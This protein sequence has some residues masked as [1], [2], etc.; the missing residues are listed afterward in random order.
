M[1]KNW[2]CWNGANA[3]TGEWLLFLDADVRTHPAAVRTT[4]DWA[5][6]EGADLATIAPRLEMKGF[7]ERVV[8]P[9]YIQIVLTYFRASHVNRDRSKQRWRTAG[10]GSSPERR[11]SN[12]GATRRSGE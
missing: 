12:W 10:P 8:L 2:A 9:L 6:R 11:T 5:V 1:G 7:W 3:T 4:L